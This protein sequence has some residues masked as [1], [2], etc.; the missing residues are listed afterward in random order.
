M[1]GFLHDT[2]LSRQKDEWLTPPDLIR[3]LGPF[4]LDPCAPVNRP[5]DTAKRHF[6][7]KENGLAQPWVGRI[8]CNPPY[9]RQTPVWLDRLRR[10]GNG[11]AL[12][13]ARVETRMFHDDVWPSADAIMFL[14]GRLAFFHLDGTSGGHAGAP[15]CLIAY[16]RNNVNALR[17]SK[18]DGVLVTEWNRISGS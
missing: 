9:G 7:L 12:V 10:H 4:D 13:F 2:W 3:S 15:S 8:W 18:L 14:K 17:D 1:S 11:L 6:T 5:W 16:G